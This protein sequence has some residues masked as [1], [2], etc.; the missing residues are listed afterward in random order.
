MELKEQLY[1]NLRK[2]ILALE[3]KQFDLNDFQANMI[4]HHTC[5]LALVLDSTLTDQ[6][7]RRVMLSI[8]PQNVKKQ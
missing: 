6:A 8:A 2:L 1:A 5:C 3:A 4:M 7:R